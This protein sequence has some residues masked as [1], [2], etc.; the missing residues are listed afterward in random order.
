MSRIV[1]PLLLASW[2]GACAHTVENAP[3]AAAGELV[4][5]TENQIRAR[6]GA[7]PRAAESFT[8][9]TTENGARIATVE[10]E[11]MLEPWPCPSGFSLV[12]PVA[13]AP[14]RSYFFRFRFREGRLVELRDLVTDQPLPQDVTL[15]IRCRKGS[16]PVRAS[17]M[18]GPMT[19]AYYLA[20]APLVAVGNLAMS[21]EGAPST[22]TDSL[23]TPTTKSDY[24]LAALRFG[25]PLPAGYLQEY[26]NVLTVT[27]RDGDDADIAVKV[28]ERSGYSPAMTNAQLEIRGG[29]L[30]AFRGN[31]GMRC[32]YVAGGGIFCPGRQSL[33]VIKR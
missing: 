9:L 17:R 5:L 23:P 1:F 29:A 7:K 11:I 3:S 8:T 2:L 16:N 30:V 27:R 28:Y 15:A 14:D 6:L 22:D 13:S 12:R 18:E 32:M 21:K 10:A 24:A 31:A 20:T 25:Q 19:T 4:G 26:S 33:F